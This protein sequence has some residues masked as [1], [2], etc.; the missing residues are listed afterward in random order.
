M[1]SH[2]HNKRWWWEGLLGLG[3]RGWGL[4]IMCYNLWLPTL[5]PPKN[6]YT[7][8]VHSVTVVH[9]QFDVQIC[10][11][12]VK[13]STCW[14]S[15]Q[16]DTVIIQTGIAPVLHEL[17]IMYNGGTPSLVKTCRC[18][19]PV[20]HAAQ[21]NVMST[22]IAICS[23]FCNSGRR[24]SCSLQPFCPIMGEVLLSGWICMSN[25]NYTYMWSSDMRPYPTMM[26][27]SL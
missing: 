17:Y 24:M 26:I 9:I 23:Q 2:P 5:K 3:H 7:H 19:T 12:W 8:A 13:W 6:I 1:S 27:S 4:M 11:S 20:M 22:A 18:I 16:H 15:F 21:F 25:Y 14:Y 10:W